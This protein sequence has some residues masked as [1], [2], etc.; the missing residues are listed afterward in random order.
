MTSLSLVSWQA[1]CLPKTTPEE[2]RRR[3]LATVFNRLHSHKKEGGS[4]PEEFRIEY[5]ADRTNTFAT[6][7]LGMTFECARCHDH[8]YDPVKTKEYYQLSSFFSNIDEYGIISFFTDAV[9][10]PAMPL[11][12]AEQTAALTAARAKVEAALTRLRLIQDEAQLAFVDW[13]QN[14][15][16]GYELKGLTAHLKFE[17]LKLPEPVEGETRSRQGPTAG[18]Q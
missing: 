14:R 16:A 5:V 4:N 13:L 12:T 10:T 9:P 15:Q 7:F 2:S 11:P 3:R 18:C 17:S 1:I 6:A 8:K